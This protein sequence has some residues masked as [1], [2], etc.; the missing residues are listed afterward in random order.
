LNT[1]M[2]ARLFFVFQANIS[3]GSDCSIGYCRVSYTAAGP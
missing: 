2:P 1:N 3:C